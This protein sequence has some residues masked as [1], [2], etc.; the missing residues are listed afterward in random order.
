MVC[1]TASRKPLFAV[2]SCLGLTIGTC[3]RSFSVEIMHNVG[4][5]GILVTICLRIIANTHGRVQG[6]A[7]NIPV[8]RALGAV[9]TASTGLSVLTNVMSTCIV[10]LYA[11]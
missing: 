9:Q 2:V 6:L 11:W 4:V 10:G 7:E 8:E 1:R 3:E 5:A